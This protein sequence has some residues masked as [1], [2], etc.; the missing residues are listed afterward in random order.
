VEDTGL[1]I[2]AD[3]MDR[4]F[5]SFSQVDA[6]NTRRFG[7]TGLG[8][9]ISSRLVGLMGGRIEVSS[10]LNVG[11]CF[12]FEVGL[13]SASPGAVPATATISASQ[14]K[15]K[16][17]LVVDDHAINRHILE[18]QL[19]AWEMVVTCAADG[20]EALARLERG[21]R[22]DFVLLDFDMPG[23]DGAQTAI[24]IKQKCAAAAP[25]VI[26]LTSRGEL[27]ETARD[28]VAAQLTKPVKPTA[29][30]AAMA[31]LLVGEVAPVAARG[32]TASPFDIRFADR[33]PMR[34]LVT[35]DN[36]VNRKVILTML[37]RLGYAATA[38]ENG[39]DALRHLARRPCDLV[40]MDMQMPVMDGVTATRLLRSVTLFG[41]PPWVLALTANARREDYDECVAAGMQDY[42]TK[43]VRTE[44]LIAALARAHGWL[45]ADGRLQR[46]TGWPELA[47]LA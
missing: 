11:S 31:R 41:Q 44:D 4:L 17:V 6:S 16:S 39:R 29:L 14:L 5:K 38:V 23:L 19:A 43:P 8:L 28:G 13:G 7:G 10:Q 20:P 15:G 37:E 33:H 3:R 27:P 42:L 12:S 1:G 40:L 47:R 35:E 46:A 32:V 34:I 45:Q 18:R 26:L 22:P 36:P 9:A 24:A 25:P 2:P 21:D 30:L